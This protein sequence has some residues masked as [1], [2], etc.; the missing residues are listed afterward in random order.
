MY[1]AQEH[2][3]PADFT[4]SLADHDHKANTGEHQSQVPATESRRRMAHANFRRPI[5]NIP[6]HL[7]QSTLHTHMPGLYVSLHHAKQAAPFELPIQMQSAMSAE[8]SDNRR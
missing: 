2:Q 1:K 5:A 4:V 3:R 6:P 7:F 8:V